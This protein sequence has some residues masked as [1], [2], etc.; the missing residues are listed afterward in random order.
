VTSRLTL[1]RAI[2]GAVGA[3]LLAGLVPAGV[4]LD[5]RLASALERRARDDLALAPQ[6][7][8][9]RVAATSDALMMHAK[10]LAHAPGLAD[11]VAGGDRARAI[12]LVEDARATLGGGDAVLVGPLGDSWIG[13]PVDSALIART[14]AGEMP[15]A[16]SAFSAIGRPSRGARERT[17]RPRARPCTVSVSVCSSAELLGMGRT[18]LWRK[19]KLYGLTPTVTDES[20]REAELG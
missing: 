5:R 6:L 14:R 13:P 16:L 17:V 18:T 20:E 7:F 19:L 4:V 10:D 8:A 11:A 1:Q 2:L 15:V 3:A 12:R 9:D